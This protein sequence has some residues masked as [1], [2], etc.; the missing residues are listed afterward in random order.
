MKSKSYSFGTYIEEAQDEILCDICK[1]FDTSVTMV[2]PSKPRRNY[3]PAVVN[4]REARPRIFYLI[5]NKNK[6]EMTLK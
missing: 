3:P 2:L 1:V 6:D 5:L 4:V